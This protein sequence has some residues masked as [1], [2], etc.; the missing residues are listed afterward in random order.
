MKRWCAAN[1][2]YFDH[3]AGLSLRLCAHGPVLA[4]NPDGLRFGRDVSKQGFD[5]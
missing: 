4:H 2:C 3:Y 5:I 1:D